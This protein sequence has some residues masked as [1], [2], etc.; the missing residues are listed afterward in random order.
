MRIRPRDGQQSRR[1][2]GVLGDHRALPAP[3]GWL[4]LGLGGSGPAFPPRWGGQRGGVRLRGRLWRRAERR[5][6]LHQRADLARPRAAPVAVGAEE[7]A[8]AGARHGGEFAG[9]RFA[10]HQPVRFLGP[11]RPGGDVGAG[12]RWRGA[13]IGHAAPAG[14]GARRERRGCGSLRVAGTGRRCGILAGAAIRARGADGAAAAGSR[15]GVGAIPDAVSGLKTEEVIGHPLIRLFPESM[16]LWQWSLKRLFDLT[17]ALFLLIVLLP[18]F[19][20][21]MILQ[22]LSGIYPVFEI[23]NCVGKYGR[24]FGLLNFATENPKTGKQPLI[25]KILYRTRLYKLPALI[26]ILLGKMSFVGPRPEK[27]EVVEKLR[28]KIKF[29]NRRFQVRPGLTGWAQVKYRYEEAL[30]FKRDQLKQD[31]FYLENM[32]LSF[33]FRIL[34]RSMLIFLGGKEAR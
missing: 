4:C 34:L 3:G 9:R 25:G 13:A 11:L 1:A 32:S 12:K 10:R 5:R 23:V 14:H 30:K 16:K 33:D 24:V 27:V 6:F 28:R 29:Y 31:L 7:D 20:L 17:F 2:Q 19:L 15:G 26:N 18:L 8:G 21:I 22:L